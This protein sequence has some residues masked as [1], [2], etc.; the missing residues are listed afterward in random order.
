MVYISILILCVVIN[1][2]LILIKF[3]SQDKNSDHRK[4]V[5]CIHQYKKD[6]GVPAVA[7]WVKDLACLCGG[8]GSSP[9]LAQWVKD[10]ALKQLCSRSHLGSD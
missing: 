1:L 7:Q 3:K 6:L 9:G 8:A 4:I 5:T 10:P 2:R